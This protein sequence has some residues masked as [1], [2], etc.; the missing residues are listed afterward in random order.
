MISDP[1]VGIG[2]DYTWGKDDSAFYFRIGE[3][4]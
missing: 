1:P 2:V 3:A 4:F